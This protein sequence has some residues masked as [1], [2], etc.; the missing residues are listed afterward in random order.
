MFPEC[1][2]PIHDL[3]ALRTYA[4]DTDS[5]VFAGTHTLRQTDGDRSHYDALDITRKDRKGWNA[6]TGM[7]V[8]PVFCGHQSLAHVKAVPS[9]F[10]HTDL[11]VTTRELNTLVPL[12]LTIRDRTLRVLPV[13][14]A[15]ALQPNAAKSQYDIVVIVAYNDGISPFLPMIQQNSQGQ[16][17]V[18]F[19][20]DGRFGASSINVVMDHRMQG[21][22]WWNEPL[23]GRLPIG[24]AV[25]VAD[26]HLDSLA[27]QFGVTNPSAPAQLISL[28]PIVGER[29]DR[30]PPRVARE[31]L[32][33]SHTDDNSTQ[34]KM[35]D[36]CLKEFRPNAI[37]EVL[38]LQLKRLASA[39]TASAEWWNCIGQTCLIPGE[40]DLRGL[41]AE[42]SS[43]AS[44][45]ADKLLVSSSIVD[46]AL[47]GKIAKLKRSCGARVAVK[48]DE[49]SVTVGQR[50]N[51]F[52]DREDET[53]QLRD[54]LDHQIQRV[55]FISGLDDVG[56]ET[57]IDAS[58]AQAGHRTPITIDLAPDVTLGFIANALAKHFR[59]PNEGI[60]SDATI[61]MM[62]DA[63]FVQRMPL[64]SILLLLNADSLKAH[65]QWRDS[66]IPDAL[67]TLV[68]AFD[69]RKG[70][71]IVVSAGRLDLPGVE[72]RFVNR[73]W[74]RGLPD[75]FGV[76]LLDQHLR[77]MGLDPSNFDNAQKQ[78]VVH[79]IG[80]H[81]GAI[82]LVADYIEQMSFGEVEEDLIRRKGV[83]TQIVRRILKRLSFTEDQLIALS[84][85]SMAR[86]PLPV[87]V[88]RQAG[89]PDAMETVRSLVHQCVVERHMNDFVALSD[90]VRGFADL[91]AQGATTEILFHKSAAETLRRLAGSGES[92]EEFRWAV[93]SRFHAH[94]AGDMNLAPNVGNLIDGL[95]GALQTLLER[96][97]YE[98]AKPLVDALL[99]TERTAELYQM[100]AIIYG[101]LGHTEESL[102]LAKEAFSIDPGRIWIVTEVGRLALH[103]RRTDIARECVNLLHRT[104]HDSAFLATLEGQILLR[105]EGEGAATAVFRR[106]TELSESE[107]R[108]D[109]WPHFY[110]GRCLLKLGK[111]ED[112][113]D[114]LFR[115]EELL[116][117]RRRP[118]RRLVIAIRTQ[119]A[120]AYVLNSDLE[121]AKRIFDL[122]TGEDAGNAE[123]V[124]AF[125]LYQ[126]AAGEASS[127]HEL[128]Q[129]TLRELKP[130][131]AKDRYGRCQV[132]LFRAL[133]YLGIGNRERASVEFSKAHKEDP[134][135]VFVLLRW[136][137]TLRDLARESK[138]DEEHQAARICAEQAKEIADRIIG[139]DNSN[140]DARQLLE[141]LSDEF[142]VQ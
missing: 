21:I 77:Q 48:N 79:N 107:G 17:P 111:T 109:A 46:D 86:V 56:K 55:M 68:H 141:E 136:A 139:F 29:S 110:Y 72:P 104:G 13:V 52:I 11:T 121:Q 78:A 1:S 76:L 8:L 28:R 57:A 123:V 90:L 117:S 127:V 41:E 87:E 18:V 96:H 6:L 63:E 91:P 95:L 19:C 85:L 3:H 5:V 71:L 47:L 73:L 97:D 102:A 27:A 69:V 60:A 26:V 49:A 24:D 59:L 35:I 118:N 132:Y 137:N 126:V 103:V 116:S 140:E 113:I 32:T 99:K 31:L 142:D 98:R 4:I 30:D 14:C 131:K 88:L 9:V 135:N 53:R 23:R 112:A 128:A 44:Q 25:L 138:R 106:G 62:K 54:F 105:E 93:E 125:A 20:N 2:I 50:M 10:E 94:L 42:L 74:M 16:I 66:R 7:T 45:L 133:I 120:I 101:R 114:V 81:P 64:G 36:G 108:S 134:R 92:A 37:Q 39:G 115:G 15:E 38:M 61:A 83:H 33:I 80:G 12:S 122:I 89:V 119:L 58:L 100:G 22:W 70:K 130:E 82:V 84:L 75:D 124:R 51:R 129:Q 40:Y 34:A 65:G 67:S 43:S